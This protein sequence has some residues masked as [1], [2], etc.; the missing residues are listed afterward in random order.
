M[1]KSFPTA[2]L[3]AGELDIIDC[4]NMRGSDKTATLNVRVCDA[5][6]AGTRAISI[7]IARTAAHSLFQ[8]FFLLSTDI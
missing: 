5:F 3:K 2:V 7:A 8:A 1:A 4:G 6:V